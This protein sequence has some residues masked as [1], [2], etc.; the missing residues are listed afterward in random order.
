MDMRKIW[1]GI[2]SMVLAASMGL[3]G[4]STGAT[5]GSASSEA[6]A[7]AAEIK[8]DSIKIDQ[9]DW[10]VDDG[11]VDGQRRVVFSYTNDSDYTVCAIDMEFQQRSDVTEED[12]A[13]FNELYERNSMWEEMNGGP[14]ELYITAVDSRLVDPGEESPAITCTFNHT[15][16]AVDNMDQY[17]LMEPSKL[18]IGYIAD[19]KK[20]VEYYDFENEEYSLDRQS[21]AKADDWPEDGLADMLPKPDSKL[22][23]SYD[24]SEERM[25]VTVYGITRAT[26]EEYVDECKD[27]GFTEGVDESDTSYEASNGNGT[28]LDLTYWV[29]DESMSVE[30][31]AAEPEEEDNVTAQT[32][33]ASNDDSAS[34]VSAELKTAMDEYEAFFDE[35][36]A[37]MQAYQADP[38]S[39]ELLAQYPSIMEQYSDTMAAMNEI[40]SSDLT[41]ADYTYYAEVSARITAK[42]AEIA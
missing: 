4:C 42:L 32:S 5:A 40:D 35:Y 30:L 15:A 13:L 20:Y 27:A 22:I 37:F 24:D 2:A 23:V 33:V 29:Y 11:M 21:G 38:S 7:A 1:A 9:I 39:T 25:S 26:Y 17:G 28:T 31:E 3:A 16:T 34:Q 19:G 6:P 14:E 12:R 18:S 8:A 36:V 10:S 41:G